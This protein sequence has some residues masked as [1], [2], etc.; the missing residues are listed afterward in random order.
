MLWTQVQVRPRKNKALQWAAQPLETPEGFV[1]LV[2][3]TIFD[4]LKHESGELEEKIFESNVRGF[5]QSTPVN[6]ASVK[7]WTAQAKPTLA[8]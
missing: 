4:F 5:W 8:V 3:S 1:G 7:L 6:W 2:N